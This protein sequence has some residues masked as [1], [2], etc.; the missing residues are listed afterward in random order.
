MDWRTFIQRIMLLLLLGML[1]IGL[2]AAGL[3]PYVALAIA[4]GIVTLLRDAWLPSSDTKAAKGKL[5]ASSLTQAT[6]ETRAAKEQQSQQEQSTVSAPDVE[7]A[8]AGATDGEPTMAD[9]TNTTSSMGGKAEAHE[10]HN[11]GRESE[12]PVDVAGNEGKAA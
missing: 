5:A 3:E 12:S 9:A 11:Q 4:G 1:V 2:I 7:T 10:Q 8:T 6:G